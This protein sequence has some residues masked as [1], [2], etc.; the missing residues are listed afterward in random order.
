MIK[1][2]KECFIGEIE[3]RREIHFETLEECI[4]YFEHTEKEVSEPP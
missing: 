1:I 2:I 3:V 4:L